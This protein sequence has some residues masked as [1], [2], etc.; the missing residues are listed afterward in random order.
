[1]GIHQFKHIGTRLLVLVGTA[2]LIGLLAMINVYTRQQEASIL[3]QNERAM[4]LV[5]EG[6]RQG[7]QT[8]MLAGYADIAQNYADNLKKVAGVEKF[9]ILRLQGLEAFRDN[10][11]IHAVN[12]RLG[13]EE[14]MPRETES[15]NQI[16]PAEDTSLKAVIAGKSEIYQYTVGED[17][18]R[19][20]VFLAPIMN[21]KP[22]WRCHGKEQELRGV[23]QLVTGLDHVEEDITH[24]R[25]QATMVLIFAMILILF[26]TFLL[27]RRSVVNPIAHL[28]R[29][30]VN[31]AN[32]NLKEKVPEVSADELGQMAHCFNQ[33]SAELLKSHTGLQNEKDKLT[34]II[35][36]AREGMVVTNRLGEVALINPAAERLLG[37][38]ADTIKSQGFLSLLDDPEYMTAML[39]PERIQKMP[40]VVVYNN[41]MLNIY[42]ATIHTSEGE[43]IGSAALLRDITEE[44]KLE[45]KLRLLST[46]DGL[47][48]LINRR[49][50]DELLLEEYSRSKRYGTTVGVMLFDVDHFK[51]FNDTHGHDQGDRVLQAVARTM[52]EVFR[53]VDYCCRYGG[54]EF[55]VIMPNTGVPGAQLAAERL[56]KAIEDM[57]VDGLKVT[58][59][60]GVA[61]HPYVPLESADAMIKSADA[62][63][64]EAKRGG[65][66]R[67]VL[68]H[69]NQQE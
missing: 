8:V 60:I 13:D 65:R 58:I 54:E 21:Q 31:V 20:L 56:R 6:T 69:P 43:T 66:N 62:H 61:V 37:K 64:Y 51:K 18:R 47:T 29:A 19:K 57:V 32:G 38:E 36:S 5:M 55:C 67:V 42:A 28:T 33:M 1:M 50:L 49:R 48:G 12:R 45:E 40:E 68:A 10:S 44:K 34:T 30:M 15:K 2:V 26:V 35:L 24:A 17:G 53:E 14:F 22:C 25:N 59:S 39:D 9:S 46:T 63:L 11:T 23:L 3:A 52:K 7:L 4:R 27:I 16:L 41:R